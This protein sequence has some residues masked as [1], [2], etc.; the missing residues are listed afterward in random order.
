MHNEDI[1][2]A[3]THDDAPDAEA[4]IAADDTGMVRQ[5]ELL[6]HTELDEGAI[7]DAESGAW[8]EAEGA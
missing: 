2:R 8:P 7:G 4:V 5:Q 6:V 3:G 1:E